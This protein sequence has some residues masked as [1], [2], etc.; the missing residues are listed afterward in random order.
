MW[1]KSTTLT[2]LRQVSVTP[3]IMPNK[4]PQKSKFPRADGVEV[5]DSSCPMIQNNVVSSF[6]VG[7]IGRG[8]TWDEHM[9]ASTDEFNRKEIVAWENIKVENATQGNGTTL[10]EMGA[11]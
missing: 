3:S 10:F 6:V 2:R 4:G 7:A 1:G 9:Q 5:F 8:M 11:V